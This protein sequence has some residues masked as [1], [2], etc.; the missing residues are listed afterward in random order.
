M[1]QTLLGCFLAVNGE[2]GCLT[3]DLVIFGGL[4][5]GFYDAMQRN[6]EHQ[7]TGM[8]VKLSGSIVRSVRN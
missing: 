4:F 6:E 7:L 2:L 5:R 8:R 3:R 1:S